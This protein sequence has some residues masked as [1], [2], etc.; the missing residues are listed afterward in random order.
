VADDGPW[1]TPSELAEYAF[2]PRAYHLRLGHPPPGSSA[3]RRGVAYHQ[4]KLSAE[5]WRD[6]HRTAPWLAVLAGIALIV[7]AVAVGGR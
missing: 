4:R 5:R 7:A 1:T 3:A 6:E 2:C